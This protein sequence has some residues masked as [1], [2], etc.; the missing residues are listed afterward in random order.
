M[1]TGQNKIFYSIVRNFLKILLIIWN[2]CSAKWKFRLPDD[3]R[4]IVACNHASN[5]D[6]VIVGCFFPRRL[7]YF[8]KE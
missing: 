3:E 1:K 7:R 6:P 8:A 2:R 5:L 4:F